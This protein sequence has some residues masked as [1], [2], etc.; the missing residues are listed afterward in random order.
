MVKNSGQPF[1]RQGS[2]LLQSFPMK[3]PKV[4]WRV[5]LVRPRNPLNI[6][7]AARALANFGLRELVVVAPY[8]PVWQE[9]RSAAVGAEQVIESARA[10]PSLLDAIGD[11]ALVAGTTTGSRRNLDRDLLPLPEFAAWLRRRKVGGRAA[12]LFGSEKT[13]LS[14]AHLS[15]CHALVR[16]PTTADCPS[17]N[18]GQAVAVCAYELARAGVVATRLPRLTVHRSEA[19]NLQSLERLFA[20]AAHVLDA[21]GYL[22]PRSRAAMLIKLRRLLLDLELT[23]HDARILGGVL[24]QVEWKLKQIMNYE[25]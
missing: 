19:A 24:A 5:V 23:N 22:K 1:T 16:I 9:A 12:L 13:G 7:A 20:R 14:N 21:S 4:N 11:T 25:C 3:P 17:M 2:F 6:G 15:L 18:L 10:V 8:E